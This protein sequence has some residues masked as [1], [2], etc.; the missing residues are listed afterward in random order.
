MELGLPFSDDDVTHSFLRM[1]QPPTKP[2]THGSAC[3]VAE[4]A[5]GAG[6]AEGEGE[7]NFPDQGLMLRYLE[8]AQIA[9]VVGDVLFVHGAVHECNKG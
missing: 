6:D 4:S 3:G 9:V 1:L 8:L 7:G 5:S 2:D